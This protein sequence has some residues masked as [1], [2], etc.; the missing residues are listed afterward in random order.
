M[1]GF[2]DD[3]KYSEPFPLLEIPSIYNNSLTTEVQKENET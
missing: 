2:K 3:F 1:L